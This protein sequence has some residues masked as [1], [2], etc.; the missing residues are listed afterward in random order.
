MTIAQQEGNAADVHGHPTIATRATGGNRTARE[1]PRTPAAAAIAG[2]DA[3]HVVVLFDLETHAGEVGFEH[4]DREL[5]EAWAGAYLRHD[6]GKAVAVCNR[7][8]A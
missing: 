1:Q 2:A 4:D 3:A 8:S 7:A 5:C 6:T